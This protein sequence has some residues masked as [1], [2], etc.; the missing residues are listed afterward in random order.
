MRDQKRV[1]AACGVV[2]VVFVAG[3]AALACVGP[4][5]AAPGVD[6]LTVRS[7]R[8]QDGDGPAV[9]ILA[10]KD[11]AGVWVG[12]PKTPEHSVCLYA[13]KQQGVVVG[14]YDGRKEMVGL[15]LALSGKDGE[16]HVQ[17]I[18]RAGK[19]H[20][21]SADELLE[22]KDAAVRAKLAK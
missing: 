2:A 22:A 6:T 12:D 10:S 19:I 17:V 7:L 21:F 14:V 13:N 8:V 20:V 9:Q 11:M 15:S 16:S 4:A 1:E 5:P 18:D 3:L